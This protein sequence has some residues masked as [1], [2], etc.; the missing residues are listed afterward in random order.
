MSVEFRPCRGTAIHRA[1]RLVIGSSRDEAK[2]AIVR[3][4]PNFAKK[5]PDGRTSQIPLWPRR[6]TQYGIFF[7]QRGKPIEIGALPSPN[8]PLHQG[9]LPVIGC[10]LEAR[11]TRS[12]TFGKC[13]TG[14]LKSAVRRSNRRFEQ[15]SGLSRRP[16]HDVAEQQ[17]RSLPG[18]QILNGRDKSEFYRFAQFVTRMGA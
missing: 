14:T 16:A 5:C 17:N 10:G 6:H 9:T 8:I 13:G 12:K 3:R 7:E 11:L 2:G 15:A 1:S 4:T 18:R